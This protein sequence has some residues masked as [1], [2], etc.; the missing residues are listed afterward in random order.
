[1][2]LKPESLLKIH[3]GNRLLGGSYS[4]IVTSGDTMNSNTPFAEFYIFHRFPDVPFL[5]RRTQSSAANMQPFDFGQFPEVFSAEA[6]LAS[7]LGNARDL[8]EFEISRR[9]HA[10]QRELFWS[11][12][13]MNF[14]ETD[15]LPLI[16]FRI[17]RRFIPE[18]AVMANFTRSQA[19]QQ[20]HNKLSAFPEVTQDEEPK[21]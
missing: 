4:I 19:V 1:M 12:S 17:F 10:L 6:L 7:A 3:R 9:D 8:F 18:R 11:A 13:P 20:L 15:D 14:D 2:P 5:Y 16:Q 21:T